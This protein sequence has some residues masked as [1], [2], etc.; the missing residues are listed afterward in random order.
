MVDAAQKLQAAVGEPAREVAGPVQAASGI[1]GIGDEPFCRQLRAV[2]IAAGDTP[3]A[4]RDLPRD[5][6]GDLPSRRIEQAQSHAVQGPA[7][8][9]PRNLPAR[10]HSEARA[11]DRALG[12]AIENTD[13]RPREDLPH[14]R[15]QGR[16]HGV[17]AHEEGPQA[18]VGVRLRTLPSHPVHDL[19]HQGGHGV[20]PGQAAE[21]GEQPV[22]VRSGREVEQ[23]AGASHQQR[24][25]QLEEEDV[26][27]EGGQAG[28]GV[29]RLETELAPARR[30]DVGQA[31]VLHHHG[32]G[33]ARS[34][35]G[36]DQ[37][38]RVSR[39]GK[40]RRIGL[41][42]DAGPGFVEADGTGAG[43]QDG[44]QAVAERP[45][46]HHHR[47]RPVAERVR[48]HEG[49][50][51]RGI[52][53][54]QRQV[55]AAG[56]EYGQQ[57]DHQVRRALQADSHRLLRT[58]AE[59]SQLMGETV[60]PG[61]QLA[62]GQDLLAED[63]GGLP[64]EAG[65][66]RS[67]PLVDGKHAAAVAA[68]AV[69]LDEELMPLGGR[70]E[71]HLPRRLRRIGG[72]L[73]KSRPQ[74]D[75]H[76]AY[77]RRLV[78]AVVAQAQAQSPARRGLEGEGIVGPLEDVDVADGERG[79]PF[80]QGLAHRIVLEHQQALEQ[81]L[82]RLHLA[83][84]LDANQRAVLELP[85]LGLPALQRRQ[86]GD[87]RGAVLALDAHRH[88]VDEQADHRLDAFELRRTAG[89]DGAEDHVRPAAVAGDQQGPGPLHQGIQG[90]PGGVG[91]L[92]ESLRVPGGE[93]EARL[94]FALPGSRIVGLQAVGSGEAR[95]G[96]SPEALGRGVVLPRQ[97]GDVVAVGARLW[98][99]GLDAQ[100]RRL[101]EGE[102]LAQQQGEAPA[103]EQ[104]VV[105]APD[106]APPPVG[107]PNEDQTH[108]GRPAQ[109]EASGTVRCQVVRQPAPLFLLGQ[110]AP[111]LPEDRQLHARTHHLQRLF[112]LLPNESRAQHRMPRHHPSPR[113]E[114]RLLVQVAFQSA[115]QLLE[116][117]LR[118]R[119]V[120]AVEQQALLH[121][122]EG[123]G[124]LD[125]LAAAQPGEQSRGERAVLRRTI[126][127]G[128][129]LHL[130]HRRQAG[131]RLLL[132][133]LAGRQP[134]PGLAG[135]R[136]DLDAEDGIPAELEEVVV[137]AHGL[138]PQQ[139][140]PD[141]RQTPLHL[142]LRRTEGPVRGR[143]R[144]RR[145]QGPAVDLAVGRQWH[146]LQDHNDAGDHVVRQ[147]LLQ[148]LAQISGAKRRR[149]ALGRDV[150]HQASVS[151][152]VLAHQ[153][154]RL[155][156]PRLLPQDGLHLS[157][158]RCGNPA[159]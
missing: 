114:E 137:P 17:A 116:V 135:P 73:A 90:E 156:H 126:F 145:R 84:P 69:P 127:A 143:R 80:G 12:R 44:R 28:H 94:G 48:H 20:E 4:D 106:E 115:A 153:G 133:H 47:L 41:I 142:G 155:A 56:L 101:V 89:D 71:H 140:R 76:A 25:Q 39:R 58:D 51:V 21:T 59:G 98:Q 88:G 158:P 34:P 119:R 75:Q 123:I 7:D 136:H 149:T 23:M 157:E 152:C 128:H 9:R 102:H 67:E 77:R 1:F 31:A 46:R 42:A 68:G 16:G 43:G 99:E 5:A 72:Q 19:A 95:Q 96:G 150:G 86:P 36:V 70:Q 78:A 11:D 91:E 125:G 87:E 30:Q 24:V 121:R 85:R 3:A 134:D 97:P 138:H 64:G 10:R 107:Q 65:R 122:R 66:L 82:A 118:A 144:L 83:P 154:H 52:G 79:V 93:P 49:E 32:L 100:P 38:C 60:G 50:P 113:L 112:Q 81:R 62:V 139:L 14:V 27:G 74:V 6:Q 40:G 110:P 117:R 120:Q 57:G 111:I 13:R 147:A 15:Q 63:Q 8:R 129:F 37:V 104:E 92:L 22:D 132:E 2:Q 109:L 35:R 105:E 61:A 131:H 26:E 45:L 148:A 146:P 108:E 33:S 151:R 103:V 53:G 18:G 29:S 54:I 159:A 55:G 141:L 124:I 130:G